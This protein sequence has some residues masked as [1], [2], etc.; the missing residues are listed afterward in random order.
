MLSTLF[1][2]D[3]SINLLD[4][5][6]ILEIHETYFEKPKGKKG[7]A[8]EIQREKFL[9]RTK[10]RLLDALKFAKE[11]VYMLFLYDEKKKV[12]G[13]IFLQNF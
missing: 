3:D 7:D 4:R 12:K 8:E 13:K 1:A 2:P 9:C 6:V 5:V 10:F 11:D